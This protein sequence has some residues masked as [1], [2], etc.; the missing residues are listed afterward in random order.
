MAFV[1]GT[2]AN[3][4]AL[5][6]AINNAC[7]LNGWTLSG[8][9]LHKGDVYARLQDVGGE[10]TVLGGTGVDGSNNL[11]GAGPAYFR[12]G[13]LTAPANVTFPLTYFIHVNASPDEVYCVVNYSTNYYQFIAFGQSSIA[14]PG[15]GAWYAG[16]IGQNSVYLNSV[17]I[18][19][20]GGGS[21]SGTGH[22]SGAFAWHTLAQDGSG[23]S[24]GAYNFSINHGLFAGDWSSVATRGDIE[25]GMAN[26]FPAVSN[27]V[28][29]SPNAWNGESVL[30]QIP[31]VIKRPSTFYSLVCQPKHSRY[32]RLDNLDPEQIL[33]I[34]PDQWKVY[35]FLSKND[36][37]RNGGSSIK[38]SGTF[39]WALRYTP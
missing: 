19:Q 18:S 15:T 31:V 8:A 7:T 25:G 27:L 34:G 13:G 29:I 23:T 32:V 17:S 28:S 38:H 2:A 20:T 21:G 4:A 22:S 11:T 10:I 6:A 5:I 35:P 9:V 12:I 14:L 24:P 16:S 39:G 37:S 36:A 26:A 30:T 33:T 1:T 3:V